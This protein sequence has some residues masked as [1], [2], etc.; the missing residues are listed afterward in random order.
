[1]IS[2]QV[3][4]GRRRS[5]RSEARKPR[6][7]SGL[8]PRPPAPPA[9]VGGGAVSSA[10]VSLASW[11]EDRRG[12]Q[13]PIRRTGC[14]PRSW[15]VPPSRGTL[16]PSSS[17]A[18]RARE[19]FLRS[20]GV[21]WRLPHPVAPRT[22]GRKWIGQ[23]SVQSGAAP[24]G[25]IPSPR[26]PGDLPCNSVPRSPFSEEFSRPRGGEGTP[27][28]R[29]PVRGALPGPARRIPGMKV[30]P[31]PWARKAPRPARR[32]TRGGRRRSSRLPK[33]ARGSHLKARGSSGT[34]SS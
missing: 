13:S 26:G 22:P 15:E 24:S 23:G 31:S 25:F 10:A 32:A 33:E 19:G 29:R 16:P 21:R 20:A 2:I 28:H 5:I 14:F 30:T 17:G 9:S 1:M 7:R 6:R 34:V 4:R 27:R 3:R 11:G 12:K 18:R 8:A